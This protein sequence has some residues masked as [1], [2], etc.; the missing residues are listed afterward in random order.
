MSSISPGSPTHNGSMRSA[1]ADSPYSGGGT[2]AFRDGSSRMS[3][4]R[5]PRAWAR[6]NR[7]SRAD[8]DA[9][10]VRHGLLFQ[11][12]DTRHHMQPVRNQ[13]CTTLSGLAFPSDVD[14]PMDDYLAMLTVFIFACSMHSTQW[15]G[16]SP[17]RGPPS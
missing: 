6:T 10:A 8:F 9:A 12:L 13:T 1:S 11:L 16:A 5:S 17:G 15:R 7:S 2:P 14:R 4:G 3:P